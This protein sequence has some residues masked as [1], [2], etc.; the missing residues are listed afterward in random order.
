MIDNRSYKEILEIAEQNKINPN[1]LAIANE[2]N[3]ILGNRVDANE[4][5]ELWCEL[6]CDAWIEDDGDCYTFSTLANALNDIISEEGKEPETIDE[7][8]RKAS[9]YL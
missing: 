8:L 9:Y 4:K 7:L 1:K 3:C 6:V 5:F 2:V